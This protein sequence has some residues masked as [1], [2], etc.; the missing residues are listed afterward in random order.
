MHILWKHD[1]RVHI[2]GLWS[3]KGR[4]SK[5]TPCEIESLENFLS[6]FLVKR[7]EGVS[8]YE[9]FSLDYT[10]IHVPFDHAESLLNYLETCEHT[11][12]IEGE[13]KCI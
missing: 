13:I 7:G 1:P 3:R 6:T 5:A 11:Y 2:N 4:I 12:H 9:S 8:L 10:S